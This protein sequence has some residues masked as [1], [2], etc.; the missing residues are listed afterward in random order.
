VV[1]ARYDPP[2]LLRELISGIDRGMKDGRPGRES[3]VAKIK[4]SL[5]DERDTIWN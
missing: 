2:L 3:S 4:R 1:L 5:A